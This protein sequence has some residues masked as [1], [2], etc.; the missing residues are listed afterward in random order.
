MAK[1]MNEVFDEIQAQI[2]EGNRMIRDGVAVTADFLSKFDELN[3]EY[4]KLVE[5]DVYS[6]LGKAENPMIEAI[7]Q[8][9][10]KVQKAS[11][12]KDPK[13]KKIA[14]FKMTEKDRQIDLLKFGKTNGLDVMWETD[15][16]LLNQALC[17]RVAD[18]LGL[19][20]AEITEIAQTYYMNKKAQ[21]KADG[22]PAISNN[23]LVK[24]LQNVIN[25]IIFDNEITDKFKCNNHDIKYLL[26]TYARKGK[27]ALSI[28]VSKDGQLRM[29]IADV[30]HR[31]VTNS[32]Y[33]VDY[34]RIE[35]KTEKPK[36]SNQKVDL[37]QIDTSTLNAELERR[38]NELGEALEAVA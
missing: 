31:I 14:E 27:K 8:Y 9:S 21:E 12:V 33:S 7:T 38:F 4:A 26:L 30:L 24:R 22:K 11:T 19:S 35:S 23:E 32:R 17:L 34:K 18:E 37:S 10:F 2:A 25:A 6:R 3:S 29:L 36:K 28:A 13:T 1:T 20:K 16:S 5:A 15:I